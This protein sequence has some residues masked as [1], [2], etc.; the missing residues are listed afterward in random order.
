MQKS[1]LERIKRCFEA[2]SN[3]LLLLEPLLDEVDVLLTDAGKTSSL[4]A[5]V[6]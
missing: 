1:F 6:G 2:L 3:V 5:N 4:S